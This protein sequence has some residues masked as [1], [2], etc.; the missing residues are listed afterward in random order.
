MP[1]SSS[2]SH[3][4]VLNVVYDKFALP[5]KL[6]R[7]IWYELTSY[8]LLNGTNK[9]KNSMKNMNAVQGSILL[10]QSGKGGTPKYYLF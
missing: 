2:P 5:M 3:S 8:L 6:L 4:G 10:A 1:C 9:F 7:D